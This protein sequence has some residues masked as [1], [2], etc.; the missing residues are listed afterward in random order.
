MLPDEVML[1]LYVMDLVVIVVI[2]AVIY[3]ILDF[4]LNR[5]SIGLMQ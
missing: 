4:V 3:I 5:D 2:V 1:L